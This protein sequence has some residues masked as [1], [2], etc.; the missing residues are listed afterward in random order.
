VLYLE[1]REPVTFIVPIAVLSGPSG[2]EN[3]NQSQASRTASDQSRIRIAGPVFRYG[4]GPTGPV[5]KD[6]P[7]IGPSVP[8]S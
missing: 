2:P 8:L 6:G 1:P 4:A 3:W 7:V 5:Y